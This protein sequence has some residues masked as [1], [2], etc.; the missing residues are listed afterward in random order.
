MRSFYGLE[1]LNSTWNLLEVSRKEVNKTSKFDSIFYK[2]ASCCNG[3]TQL[4]EF[5]KCF[6]LRT[7]ENRKK[8]RKVLIWIVSCKMFVKDWWFYLEMFLCITSKSLKNPSLNISN[9]WN[10][11]IIIEKQNF[12]HTLKSLKKSSI[13]ASINPEFEEMKLLTP[14]MFSIF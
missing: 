1:D 12:L 13:K 9:C 2:Q 8:I 10:C 6:F 11:L 4:N 5:S 3:L 14:K 7:I